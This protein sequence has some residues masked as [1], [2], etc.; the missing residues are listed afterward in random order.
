MAQTIDGV[1]GLER[2]PAR[3]TEISKVKYRTPELRGN[4]GITP[5]VRSDLLTVFVQT[6]KYGGEQELH[7]HPALD[8]FWMVLKGRAHF[9]GEGPEPVA[10]IGPM[11]GVFIPRDAAY[12]FESVGDDVLELLQ[13]EAR[14]PNIKNTYRRL[15]K[16]PTPLKVGIYKPEGEFVLETEVDLEA[17][18]R[19]G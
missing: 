2:N 18:N 4:R 7:A 12:W 13:V 3:K 9:Y 1:E 17:R 14:D 8:G 10:D 19:E 15:R 11:E 16:S 5:L 6:V